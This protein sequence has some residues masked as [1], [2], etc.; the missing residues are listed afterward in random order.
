MVRM[1]A[2]QRSIKGQILRGTIGLRKIKGWIQ[3][4]S[5]GAVV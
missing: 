5:D 2:M 4:F 1:G 3:K